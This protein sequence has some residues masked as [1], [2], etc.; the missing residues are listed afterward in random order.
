MN[1]KPRFLTKVLGGGP[2]PSAATNESFDTSNLESP[3][4][5]PSASQ[6]TVYS[7]GAPI[8]CLDRSSNGQRAVIAGS[9]VFK[10]LRID[11]STIT[12]DVDLRAAITSYATTHDHS[13]ATSDQ[14][15]IRTVKWSHSSLDSTIVTASGNG[16]ITIY[17][18]NRG[19]EGFEV[20]R[21]QDHVRQVHK[22]AICPHKDNWLLSASQDGT[23]RFFDIRTPQ[24]DRNGTT[25]GA[26]RTFK[27]N[28]DAVRDVKWSP[29]DGVEFACCTDQGVVQK[30]D[31]R[32][33][34]A[35]VLKIQA[36]TNS[37]RSISWHPDG[38]HL[39]SG[40]ADQMCKV[41]DMSKKADRNQKPSYSFT[42]PAPISRVTWRPPCWSATAQGKRAAQITVA[43]DDSNSAKNQTASVHVWDLARSAMP[44]KEIE[45]WDSAPTAMLWNSRDLL[46]SVDKEGNFTQTDVA[47]VPKLID[48]RSLSTFAFSPNGDILML[49]EERQA[50]RRS[51]PSITTPEVSPGFSH[52]GSGPLLSVSRSDSEEDVV[53]SFLGPRQRKGHR[54]RNSGRSG[55]TLSTTP[56]S[57][58]GIADNKVM[59]LDEA[60]KVTG[61]Y[62][63]QQVM[64][65]GHAP[66]AIKRST[67]QYFS[68]RYLL[69][70]SKHFSDD[71]SP[72]MD[73][74]IACITE[75]YAETAEDVG[76]FR[77][78]QTWRLLG[79]TMQLLLSRR[80]EYHRQSR[81]AVPEPSK[82]PSRQEQEKESILP[83]AT[84]SEVGEETPRK[85]HHGGHSKLDSPL[86]RGAMSLIAEDVEST[87][88]VAT[89][90]VR[91]AR[92]HIPIETRDMH[93][94]IPADEDDL[95]L[96][97][98]AHPKTPSP[99]PVPGTKQS[100]EQPS[101]SV[102]GYD[103]YGMES[104][105]PALDFVAP[106]RKPPLRLDYHEQESHPPRIQPQ[107]HDSGESFQM[108]STSGDSQNKFMSSDGS[109]SHSF[110]RED[111]LALRDRVHEWESSQSPH[112]KHRAS[113]D[114][115]APTHSDSSLG[116]HTPDSTDIERA[117]S[118]G[119]PFNPSAPPVFRIQEASVPSAPEAQRLRSPPITG[120]ASPMSFDKASETPSQDPNIIASDFYP[121]PTDPP[122]LIS[123]IDPAVLV[124]R[125]IDFE[126]QTSAL[127]ASAIILLFRF[128]LPPSAV[129]DLQASAVLRQYHHRLTSMKLF[130]E[131]A[132]LRNLC[133][134]AYPHVFA[135][136]QEDVKIGFFCTSCNK[137]IENDP[138]IPDSMWRCPRCGENIAPC[139]VCL[140]RELDTS[141]LYEGLAEE[142][143]KLPTWFLC[144]GCGHGGHTT[145][146]LAWHLAE[147]EA[148]S[149]GCCPLEGCL[150]P[151][152]PGKWRDE[153]AEEKRV[154]KEREMD[155]LIKEGQRLGIKGGRSVR[156][157]QREVGQS[158]AVEGVRVALG[159]TGLSGSGSIER[160]KSVKLVAPGEE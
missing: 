45:Q 136:A 74:R 159:I 109:D 57:A 120:T 160:K 8:A 155:A 94:P 31:I 20:V 48:R 135:T 111:S 89:P 58:P 98:A 150:H 21:I 11:G 82:P 113:I 7:A 78:A 30:W 85:I 69:Q 47:F 36:H 6:N 124:Q 9:K 62:K 143:L 3:Q 119:V 60:V 122:F 127:H 100:P 154:A 144:P 23:V 77:L 103:F 75:S 139:A 121:W 16:R 118:N 130:T 50:P 106:K 12:E 19:G 34:T 27:C 90:I 26:R 123:P 145:C 52:H 153:R 104:F 67:Y 99:I 54:R 25:F 32:K 61:T 133:V 149:E 41:W 96:P 146:M 134:P 148:F 2:P 59:S 5:R 138:N 64:A 86:Y 83:S 117:A 80:A 53:G 1:K 35:P 92:D 79:F 141:I 65:I 107:R 93:T 40:G 129:D 125:T 44:F 140:S 39:V 68:N 15:N 102:E 91:P 22:L 13:A 33:P 84:Q 38:D 17:D 10:I 88:N 151:C 95:T 116:G 157:D 126:V 108:F 18:L 114:S 28:A 51:R 87:S 66:G 81:L 46:W 42:T 71:D 24:P 72:D 70:M 137:P 105:S 97:E 152:L 55:H 49:L 158:R 112:V 29:S 37:C 132:T 131:A 101:S 110:R 56:P 76:Y 63:P 142:E 73:V 128:L 115:N 147:G 156:R 14:L 43:Y 4:L